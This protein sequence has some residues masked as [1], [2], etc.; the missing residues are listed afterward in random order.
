MQGHRACTGKPRFQ[1]RLLPHPPSSGSLAA[2]RTH[3]SCHEAN[4]SW[5][6][7]PGT[8]NLQ[9]LGTICLASV[10]RDFTVRVSPFTLSHR[11]WACV[12]P[13]PLPFAP[14]S[15]YCLLVPATYR[16]GRQAPI[17]RIDHD[18]AHHSLTHP[19]HPHHHTHRQGAC[20]AAWCAVF[21][22]DPLIPSPGPPMTLATTL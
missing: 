3:A 18:S 11:V 2:G 16:W 1:R 5:L 15:F 17:K 10:K 22:W 12:A 14:F 19:T 20:K 6:P 9:T 8:K 21:L 4:S 7:I 13:R